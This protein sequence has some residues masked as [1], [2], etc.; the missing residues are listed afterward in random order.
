[1]ELLSGMP[2]LRL[3]KCRHFRMRTVGGTHEKV[4]LGTGVTSFLPYLSI[5]VADTPIFGV[6]GEVRAPHEGLP[7]T[8][9][10]RMKRWTIELRSVPPGSQLVGRPSEPPAEDSFS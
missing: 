6:L 3:R 4:P 9:G 7:P 2:L 10:T 1:M 5:Y 8:K